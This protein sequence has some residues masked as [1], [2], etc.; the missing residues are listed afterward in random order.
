MICGALQ[1]LNEEACEDILDEANDGDPEIP[2]TFVVPPS[3]ENA[4]GESIQPTAGQSSSQLRTSIYSKSKK[5]SYKEDKS[6]L[7]PTIT[8]LEPQSV[9]SNSNLSNMSLSL[10][11]SADMKLD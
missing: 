1:T 10:S 9:T 6:Y 3:P 8:I 5:V 4:Q 11:T 7:E 2:I